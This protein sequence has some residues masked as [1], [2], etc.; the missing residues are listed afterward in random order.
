MNQK[1]K[2]LKDEF[3][4]AVL[5]SYSVV[6]FSNNRLLSLVLLAVTFL[7]FFAGLSGLIAVIMVTLIARAMGF[8]KTLLKQGIYSFNA[9]LAGIGLGTFFDPGLVF[10]TILFL[11]ALFSLI[12]SVVLSGWLGKYGLPFLSIPFVLSFWLVFLPSGQF[13]NLGLTQRNVFWMNEMYA[14]G[15]QPLL[16]FFQTIDNLP[17]NKMAVIY[18]HSISSVFFQDNLVAGIVIAAALIISSR[19]T[20]LLSVAGFATAYLFAHFTGSEMAS[21]SFYN[22]GA[23]YILIA[24]AIGG[25][26]IV[27][28]TWSFLWAMIMVP[29]TSLVI[30]FM[31]KLLGYFQLPVFSLPFSIVTIIFIYFL[32]LR[33][34]SGK[35]VLTQIQHFSPEKN[36]YSH[37]NNIDRLS[38]I[39]FFPLH[40]PFWGE[41]KVSQGCNGRHTHKGEWSSAIDFVIIDE[42]NRTHSES[43][44]NCNEYYCFKKPVVA[45]ADGVVV[46][47]IDNIIENEP[48]QVN[49]VHNWGNTVIIRHLNNLFT[50]LSHL[51]PGS[52]KVSKGDF[53]RKGDLIATCG[54]SGRSPEPHLHFQ[55]QS[56]PVQGSKTIEYPFSYYLQQINNNLHLKSFTIPEEGDIISNISTT[57]LL[58]SAYDFQPGMVIKFQYGRN[59]EPAR[60]ATW[61]VFTDAY[62]SK[63]F[64]DAD[65]QSSAYFV[66]DGT[67]FYF[68]TFY[69]DRNSLL[70]HFYLISY[71]VIMC[72]Y[73]DMEI[74]DLI[75]L[76]VIKRNSLLIWLHDFAAPFHQYLRVHY[77]SSN[78]WSDVS[79][80]PANIKLSS[81]INI[82]I[83]KRRHS[84][85]KGTL[86]FSGNMISEFTFESDKIS[87]WAKRSEII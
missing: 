50:Q 64:F 77:S 5:N 28:S 86:I 85:A 84:E 65:S 72:N 12:L 27:P 20:F 80:N 74:S 10:F 11:A 24:I 16:D 63:Y 61:E 60:N 46:E 34:R 25:F 75:P 51:H 1:F 79:V 41:W 70:Y 73:R 62:N 19:I 54:N 31:T 81:R 23:N 8:D 82:S 30:L 26:F 37:I 44:E 52:V 40:L 35:L 67:M 68:T 56:N 83:L 21:F 9:L 15:G 7:N 87:I 71:K 14:I 55:V 57:P 32:L 49:T 59:N 18:L 4:P 13:E 38:Q 47:V 53:V 2:L 78:L 76:H 22:V 45:P 58:I 66:N 43:G 29:L 69:G 33:V 3:I 42:F 39:K 17:L 48:G 6:F 36:L